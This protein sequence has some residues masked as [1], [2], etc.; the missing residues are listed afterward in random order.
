MRDIVGIPGNHP[1]NPPRKYEFQ[2]FSVKIMQPV[3]PFSPH[4]VESA[5]AL[6]PPL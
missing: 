5:A 2:L 4:S 6:R 3:S 1:H